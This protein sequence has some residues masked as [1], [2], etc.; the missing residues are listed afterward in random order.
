M[1]RHVIDTIF[2]KIRIQKI[3]EEVSGQ[4]RSL[5]TNGK[6]LPGEKLP[7]ERVFS[8]M[9]GVGR[10]SLREAINILETQGFLKT[11][12]RKGIFVCNL[13]N[14]LIG[15]PLRQILEEGEDKL[16]QLYE[17]R[18]DIELSAA[19][20]A[21]KFRTEEHLSHMKKLLTRMEKNLKTSTQNFKDEVGFHMIIAQSSNN[22]FRNYILHSIFELSHDHLQSFMNAY[23]KKKP[24]AKAL[25][26]DH[27]SIYDAIEKGD[28][29]LARSRM[30][31]HLA[32]GK[33]YF[34]KITNKSGLFAE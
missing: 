2:K 7:P 25:H 27:L 11:E 1:R 32:R 31:D 23:G 9:L 30:K 20:M 14:Q 22:I 6:L 15:D 8:E 4:I 33:R 10:S 17:V 24:N 3:S 29:D 26:A 16:L 28:Q 5:I 12:K 21:A 19:F 34:E 18:L 13:G